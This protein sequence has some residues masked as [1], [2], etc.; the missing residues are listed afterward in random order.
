MAAIHVAW[1]NVEN[2]FDVEDSPR[3]SEKLTRVLGS[4]LEG[5]TAGLLERK[6]DRLASVI[7]GMNAG[8]GPDLLGV[9]EVENE[10]V[11]RL[12]AEAVRSRL[13]RPF[14]TAHADTSDRRGIDIAFLYDPDLLQVPPEAVYQH[15]VMRR[16]GTREILQVNFRTRAGTTWAVFGNHWP[17]RSGGRWESAAYRAVAGETLAYFHQRALE[18][19]GP[20]TPV[21]AMGDFNDEPFDTSLVQHAV[22]TRQR[23]KVL[24]AVSVPRLWNLMWPPLGS[25]APDGSDRGPTGTFYFNNFANMLDQFLVNRNMVTRGSPLRALPESVRIVHDP[26]DMVSTGTYPSPVGFGGMGKPVD[27]SGYSDHY[28]V[29]MDVETSE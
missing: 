23:A 25:E 5:W 14:R 27:T 13:G 4:S 2:L 28:P 11:L 29:T 10:H 18:V 21:L 7:A 24:N 9:C 15:V 3:R 12:L 26:K 19:H 20:R 1:W 17:S 8:R 16:T 22:S 6:V